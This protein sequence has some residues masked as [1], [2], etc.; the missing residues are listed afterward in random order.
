MG[1]LRIPLNYFP[2]PMGEGARREGEGL[3]VREK[4]DLR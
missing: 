1:K 4:P 2:S 3:P